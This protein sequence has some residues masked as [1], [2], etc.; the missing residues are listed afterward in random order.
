MYEME[1]G[2]DGGGCG[3]CAVTEVRGRTEDVGPRMTVTVNTYVWNM[4]VGGRGD[5]GQTTAT[6][7]HPC[8][9]TTPTT[10]HKNGMLLEI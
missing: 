10:Q 9:K 7:R 4:V 3:W 1:G 6:D 2:Q 8:A 5:R